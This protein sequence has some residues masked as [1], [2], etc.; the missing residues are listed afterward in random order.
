MVDSPAGNETAG[1]LVARQ[2]IARGRAA[3]RPTGVVVGTESRRR[4]KSCLYQ[5][6]VKDLDRLLRDPDIHVDRGT[7][8][9]NNMLGIIM[10]LNIIG[11]NDDKCAISMVK[12]GALVIYTYI[13][14]I[15]EQDEKI[16]AA[17]GICMFSWTCWERTKN[18]EGCIEGESE[19]F[20]N[21]FIKR[22]SRLQRVLR[23]FLRIPVS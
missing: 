23:I 2:G 15:G 17:D 19:P 14:Q 5:K 20:V 9:P 12:R 21:H 4:N 1:L 11:K 10:E 3:R 16:A 18:E 13:L 7:A 6:C 8:P 22:P